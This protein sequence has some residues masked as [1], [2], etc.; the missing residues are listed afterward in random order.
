MR[1]IPLMNLVILTLLASG[2]YL[3]ADGRVFKKIFRPIVTPITPAPRPRAQPREA[4]ANRSWTVDG[5]GEAGF[6]DV[7]VRVMSLGG[8]LVMWGKKRD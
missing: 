1:P 8:G 6:V 4:E 5:W 7:G 3:H 2:P